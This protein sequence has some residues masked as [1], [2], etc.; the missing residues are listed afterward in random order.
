MF[1]EFLRLKESPALLKLLTHYAELGAAD[2]QVWQDRLM[3]LE[4]AEPKELTKLHG[5]L[6]A[7]S[8]VDQNTGAIPIL[9]PGVVAGC[10]RITLVGQR[11]HRYSRGEWSPED[12]N[13]SESSTEK[14]RA[15]HGTDRGEKKPRGKRGAKTA[16]ATD[17]PANA[18][19]GE[20]LAGIAAASE[21]N[22]SESNSIPHE[23]A[24]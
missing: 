21:M 17:E 19:V 6:I 23:V 20:S 3:A 18:G 10:Y 5:E 24:A 14:R 2:R 11:A 1:D 12:E 8:W 4:G 13:E 15:T 9:K 16:A 22:A 7:Y